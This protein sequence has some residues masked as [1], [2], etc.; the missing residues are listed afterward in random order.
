MSFPADIPFINELGFLGGYLRFDELYVMQKERHKLVHTNDWTSKAAQSQRHCR[1]VKQRS[2]KENLTL[3]ISWNAQ[4]SHGPKFLHKESWLKLIISLIYTTMYILM[5]LFWLPWTCF[6]RVFDHDFHSFCTQMQACQMISSSSNVTPISL[7]G[8]KS[9][10]NTDD[11][12]S[13]VLQTN[14]EHEFSSCLIMFSFVKY[15]RCSFYAAIYS[16]GF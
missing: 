6:P 11:I 5:Y 13:P 12:K 16:L 2:H 4:Q 8:S 14:S 3:P 15:F 1:E 9:T 7:V 10:S